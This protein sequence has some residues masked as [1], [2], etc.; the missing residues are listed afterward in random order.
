MKYDKILVTG[1]SGMVGKSLK[2]IMPNAVYLSSKDYNLTSETEIWKMLDDNQPDAI[3][4]LAAKVGGIIDNINKPAE[5]FTDNILMNTHL[6]NCANDYGVKRFISILS[7]CIYPDIQDNY[8]MC[9]SELHDGPPTPTNFSY[10]YAKRCL[11]V[12]TEAY[13]K[14][15]G[16]KYQY[17]IPCNL[18]GEFDKF[19]DNSHFI[20]AL[21]KKI[22]FAKKNGDDKIVLFGTGK[23]LRQFM[24]SDDL[25]S[26][27]K[28]CIDN[29]IYENMNVATE[30]NL[31]IR[32]MAEIALDAC[33]AKGLTVQ[34]DS[35][36][37]DGQFRK[38]VSIQKLKEAIPD[39]TTID[40][41]QG[42]KQTY[43]YITDNNLI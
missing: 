15:Y 42:I 26:V 6:I 7:T 22:H 9:E 29:D 11:A 2:K 37:P 21:I 23:P 30:E 31:S 33:D 12:Q 43:S 17:L 3:I 35:N 36:Y 40:L 10:G 8:P 19:G 38:D 24:H 13:N 1:G 27:I 32:Q 4:H 20:A 18:Y 25:A 41:Y 16:A 5:Y 34:F 28:N 39:F 14:Q